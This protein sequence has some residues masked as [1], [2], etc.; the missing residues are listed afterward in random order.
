VTA[1]HI[2]PTAIAAIQ[3]PDPFTRVPRRATPTKGAPATYDDLVACSP[4]G[5][6]YAHR[7][8]LEALAP[9]AV[10]VLEVRHGGALL[11]AWPIVQMSG[12]NGDG[13]HRVRLGVGLSDGL[14]RGS[15][16]SLNN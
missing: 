2:E 3:R 14:N 9:G 15:G 7:W 10:E 1:V 8:W 12:R 16:S 4:Q 11:A 5:S 6:I 13:R